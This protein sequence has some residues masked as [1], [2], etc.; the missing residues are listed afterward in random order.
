MIAIARETATAGGIDDYFA[1]MRA[2]AAADDGGPLW[3]LLGLALMAGSCAVTV[4]AFGLAV[5]ACRR[6]TG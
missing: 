4:S 3:K 2:E 5:M 1:E 6:L